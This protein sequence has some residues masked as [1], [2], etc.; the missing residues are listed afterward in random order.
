MQLDKANNQN[1]KSQK[2]PQTMLQ[3]EAEL[4]FKDI[5][6]CK[7]KGKELSEDQIRFWI[8]GIIQDA[9]PYYQQTSLLMAIYFQKMSILETAY[10]TNEM[11]Q[12]G[13]I[14]NYQ[15]IQGFRVDKHSTGGIGDKTTLLLVPLMAS[16]GIK[17]P[18]VSGRGLGHTGGTVDKIESIQGFRTDLNME[19]MRESIKQVGGF[20]NG[21]TEEIAPADKIIYSLRD[22]TET[23]DEISLITSSILSKKFAE[24]LGGL[25]LDVKCGS[26]ALLQDFEESLSLANY[27][28]EVANTAGLMC[29][30]L[31]TKMD[32]PLGNFVGNSAEVYEALKFM[33]IGSEY[34]KI[35]EKRVIFD[36]NFV[37]KLR[38]ENGVQGA[39]DNLVY[40]VVSLALNM[41][42][43]SGV[44]SAEG[45]EKI[46]NAFKNGL[47]LKKFREIVMQQR[48]DLD[49]FQKGYE[50]IVQELESFQ[51]EDKESN[52]NVYCLKAPFKCKIKKI[53]SKKIGLL[54]SQLGSGRQLI[55][56]QID[57]DVSLQFL[58]YQNQILE[59]GEIIC[60]IYHPKPEK[61]RDLLNR[62]DKELLGAFEF[63]QDLE[64]Q[65]ESPLSSEYNTGQN[66][67]NNDKNENNN[68]NSNKKC[69]N[70][71]KQQVNLESLMQ[72]K[73]KMGYQK[74]SKL[75]KSSLDIIENQKNKSLSPEKKKIRKFQPYQKSSHLVNRSEILLEKERKKKNSV[76]IKQSLEQQLDKQQQLKNFELE[77]DQ[78]RNKNQLYD[79]MQQQKKQQIQKKLFESFFNK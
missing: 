50:K 43:L 34:Q 78:E 21:Q 4:R 10:L 31:I 3:Q 2:G 57:P 36:Q 14:I 38:L 15:G 52:E 45:L 39:K 22:V 1:K 30:A 40:I 69:S 62:I 41:L 58:S 27:L 18:N 79:Q 12:S 9:I 32:Y 61:H 51:G 77:N 23:T 55:K 74:Y 63:T 16:L 19:E 28:V 7:K 76:E 68:Q 56:D 24:G 13:K 67:D 75:K 59:E 35:L 70:A 65:D 20:I 66:Q 49:K 44:E 46:K 53:N 17:T 73:Q 6:Y 37:T 48:G 71:S 33:E 29:E 42:E 11:A 26:G 5:L 72:Q 64:F 47:V 25:T 8:Q 60:K 54:M